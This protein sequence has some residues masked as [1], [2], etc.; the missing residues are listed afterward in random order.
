M[1]HNCDDINSP[2]V[3]RVRPVRH[4]PRSM[5]ARTP[6]RFITALALQLLHI[7]A[8]CSLCIVVVVSLP[9]SHITHTRYSLTSAIA[10]IR[11]LPYVLPR[12]WLIA[13]NRNAPNHRRAVG[14]KSSSTWVYEHHCTVRI[15]IYSRRTHRT[16]WRLAR[17]AHHPQQA[18]RQMLPV[19]SQGQDHG[20]G[21]CHGLTCCPRSKHWR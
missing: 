21:I 3:Y 6:R 9:H 2:D 16:G 15:C 7:E 17:Y 18:V 10:T 20:L 13:V 14:M 11:R 4:S 12:Y 8:S 5:G 1:G 19:H